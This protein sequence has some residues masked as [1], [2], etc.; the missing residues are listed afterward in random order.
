MWLNRLLADLFFFE[1]GGGWGGRGHLSAD[2]ACLVVLC[3]VGFNAD[4]QHR[5]IQQLA[6]HQPAW[7]TAD[8]PTPVLLVG[9]GLPI[10]N[11]PRKSI[12]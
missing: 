2:H 7:G 3:V 8:Q 12:V 5:Q 6:T 9:V 1:A 4:G 11:V 10:T